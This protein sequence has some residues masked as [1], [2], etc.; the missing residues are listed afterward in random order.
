MEYVKY[1]TD[2]YVTNTEHVNVS[3]K[4]KSGWRS[5]KWLTNREASCQPRRCDV[6]RKVKRGLVETKSVNRHE[7]NRHGECLAYK[8]VVVYFLERGDMSVMLNVVLAVNANNMR[9]SCIFM[10]V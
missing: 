4:R 9:M 7:E 2:F 8:T 1:K 10:P 3:R 6:E 5:S